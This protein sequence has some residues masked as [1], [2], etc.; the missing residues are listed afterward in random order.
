MAIIKNDFFMKDQK[1]WR[2]ARICYGTYNTK[3]YSIKEY[4]TKAGLEKGLKSYGYKMSHPYSGEQWNS[5]GRQYTV[6]F[7]YE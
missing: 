4:K 5:N 2:S 1:K 3:G 7:D 6:R